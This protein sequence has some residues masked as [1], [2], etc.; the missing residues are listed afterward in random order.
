MPGSRPA[1]DIGPRL[2]PITSSAGDSASFVGMGR[3]VCGKVF[4]MSEEPASERDERRTFWFLALF[5][6]PILAVVV[7]GGFGFAVW[8]SQIL[9]GPPGS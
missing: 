5:A 6:G 2:T 4:R 3:I 1:L 8:I 7:V 9:T